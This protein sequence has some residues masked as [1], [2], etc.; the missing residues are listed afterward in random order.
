MN[1]PMRV[2]GFLA[3]LAVV[4]AAAFGIGAATDPAAPVPADPTHTS[5]TG[6]SDVPTEPRVSG[7]PPP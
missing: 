7:T 2:G 5:D 1:T 4:F 3:G 6:H